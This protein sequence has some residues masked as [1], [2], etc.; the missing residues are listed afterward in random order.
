MYIEKEKLNAFWVQYKSLKKDAQNG[1]LVS[2]KNRNLFASIFRLHESYFGKARMT[3][4]KLII[5]ND[6][7]NTNSPIDFDT[8]KRELQVD[9]YDNYNHIIFADNT[10]AIYDLITQLI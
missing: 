2:L 10:D 5:V 4:F 6:D 8:V 1:S 7:S 9:N 3:Q